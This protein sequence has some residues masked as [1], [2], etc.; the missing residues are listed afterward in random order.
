MAAP[1]YNLVIQRKAPAGTDPR[2]NKAPTINV[3]AGFSNGKTVLIQVDDG[4]V[5]D[6][7]MMETHRLI[8]F[9]RK[10]Y[11]NGGKEG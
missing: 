10:P 7:R 5:I 3:G 11:K 1:D 8:L 4:V 2:D 6:W 9:P